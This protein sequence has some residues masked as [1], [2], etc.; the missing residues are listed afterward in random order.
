MTRHMESQHDINKDILSQA[1][2][3]CLD[4]ILGGRDVIALHF[5]RHLEE[6][7]LAVLPTSAGSDNGSDESGS[8]TQEDV[9]IKVTPAAPPDLVLP[10]PA[11]SESGDVQ[12]AK[13]STES[14]FV[15]PRLGRTLMCEICGCAVYETDLHSHMKHH[16]RSYGCTRYRCYK[17]YKT[18]HDWKRHETAHFQDE[19]FRCGLF[20][21]VLKSDS[22]CGAYFSRKEDFAEH[23]KSQH[24]ITGLKDISSEIRKSR[25]GRNW[26]KT[27]WCGFCASI[28]PL[29]TKQN[30]AWMEG[31]EHISRHFEH[32][33]RKIE[34]WICAETNLPKGLP[35]NRDNVLEGFGSIPRGAST[36]QKGEVRNQ[37]LS[38]TEPSTPYTRYTPPPPSLRYPPP[39]LSPRHAPPP[40]S[41]RHAPPPL[42]PRHAPPP[43]SPR[44]APPPLSP[45]HAPL[46]LSS[47]YTPYT[48]YTH[49]VPVADV[50][51]L[52]DMRPNNTNHTR[53][54]TADHE[55]GKM[56]PPPLPQ[57]FSPQ[58]R[59][60]DH[61]NNQLKCNE[62]PKS[63]QNGSDL[64]YVSQCTRQST[65]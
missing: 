13:K 43:L 37:E 1:C 8:D 22:D 31:L 26:Q 51:N 55:R 4:P 49:N 32:E 50:E 57:S 3:L 28:I 58:A 40:L 20:I 7:A 63:F 6:I 60:L 64:K 2:P 21:N 35:D 61:H 36:L 27:F 46:P 12:S 54:T 56:L 18:K 33:A 19:A 5:A 24:S 52:N 9:V 47:R 53:K 45:R 14:I 34:D 42:S 25:I 48:R 29:K 17:T 16:E 23:L 62:C 44:H 30:A 59:Q 11:N 65:V 38:D 39:P 15:E 10:K 41:P